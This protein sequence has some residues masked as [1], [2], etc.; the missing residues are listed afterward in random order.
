MAKSK[1]DKQNEKYALLIISFS[2]ILII[3]A[4]VFT[5]KPNPKNSVINNNYTQIPRITIP[6]NSSNGEAH[7]LLAEFYIDIPKENI[8]KV[9]TEDIKSTITDI[10]EKHTYETLSQKDIISSVTDDIKNKLQI[11][12]PDL[13][14]K[15]VYIENFL[16]DFSLTQPTTSNRFEMFKQK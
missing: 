10:L 6:L 16:V 9:S 14:I 13:D 4:V 15:D 1:K 12:Y 2:L 5:Y 7:T 3:C 11:A 8:E